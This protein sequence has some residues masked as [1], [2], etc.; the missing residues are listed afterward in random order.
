MDHIRF[1]K[2]VFSEPDPDDFDVALPA[3]EGTSV[4]TQRL[5]LRLRRRYRL[6]QNWKIPGIRLDLSGIGG[7]RPKCK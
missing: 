7:S 3:A 5:R 1:G 6:G 4:D 2:A